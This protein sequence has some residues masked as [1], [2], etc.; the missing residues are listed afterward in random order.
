MAYFRDM[1]HTLYLFWPSTRRR[2]LAL[3]NDVTGDHHR[4][5]AFSSSKKPVF[6]SQGRPTGSRLVIN[7]D[8]SAQQDVDLKARLLDMP[9]SIGWPNLPAQPSFPPVH[10]DVTAKDNLGPGS[11]L[12]ARLGT[13]SSWVNNSPVNTMYYSQRYPCPQPHSK[14]CSCHKGQD[15]QF[16]SFLQ[17]PILQTSIYSC[18]NTY[19]T[20]GKI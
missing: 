7:L 2:E 3:A 14:S 13:R 8:L 5:S 20:E 6:I 17:S 18:H 4:T 1:T 19:N 12:R 10:Y 11:F 15:P 9:F 16:N